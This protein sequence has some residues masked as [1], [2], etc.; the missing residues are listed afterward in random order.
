MKSSCALLMMTLLGVV[1]PYRLAL[2]GYHYEF[3]RDHFNHPDFQTE[4][5]YYTGNLKAADGHRFGFE[6]TFFRRAVARNPG[7]ESPWKLDDL[8]VAHLALSDITGQRFYHTARLNRSGPGFAGADL[9]DSR[10]WNGNWE[11][12]WK[13]PAPAGFSTSQELRAFDNDFTLDLQI[14]SRKPPVIHGKDGVSQKAEGA[15][16]ASH[17][18]SF[19]R[20]DTH[21][22]IQVARKQYTVTGASWMDHEFFTHQL[23]DALAGWDWFSLQFD[24]SS[25]L[26]LFRLRRKDGKADPYSAGTFIDAR[27]NARHLSYGEFSLRPGEPWTSPVTKGV[28]PIAWNVAVPSLSIDVNVSTPLA[29]QEMTSSKGYT[30]S[31]WEGAIDVNGTKH[32]W[33][34]LEM[35]GYAGTVGL[36]GL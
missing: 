11:A 3:P 29:A 35:T 24:D 12:D 23:E 17:Y 9:A 13:I 10:V 32:G 25:E 18:V 28:Y 36:G 7:D 30:P 27:G 5:W 33:G 2:P 22:T 15:G 19:T 4:W 1:S 26:M 21:G 20:L 16:H 34:Y 6:L 14:E 31:Y 8:Y